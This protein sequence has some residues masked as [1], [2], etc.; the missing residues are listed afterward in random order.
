MLAMDVMSRNLVTVR[1]HMPARAAAALLV[2]HGF[3]SAPVVTAEGKLRGIVTEADL[4]RGQPLLEAEPICGAPDT[5]VG[6]VMAPEPVT[7]RP[8]DDLA[9]IV[10]V[11]LADGLRSVP[12][13][14][15]GRLVGI[16]TRRDTLQGVVRGELVAR[17]ADVDLIAA[18]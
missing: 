11:M 9:A 4:M 15:D 17:G 1:P 14:E 3:T 13:V 18:P 6:E 16:I 8:T 10:A 5:T 7:V 2:A 12:V